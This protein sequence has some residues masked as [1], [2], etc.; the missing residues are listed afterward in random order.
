MH[1]L[2][3]CPVAKLQLQRKKNNVEGKLNYLFIYFCIMLCCKMK[4]NKQD[5]S[6]NEQVLMGKACIKKGDQC[7]KGNKLLYNK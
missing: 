1:L 2:H 6:G 4:C 3:L 7:R 5:R